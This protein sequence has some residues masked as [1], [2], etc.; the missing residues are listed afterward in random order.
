MHGVAVSWSDEASAGAAMLLEWLTDADF[1][2][3]V[4]VRYQQAVSGSALA[5]IAA[6]TAMP[7]TELAGYPAAAGAPTEAPA[8]AGSGRTR[9][10][11]LI[12]AIS[13]LTLGAL[14]FVG[15]VAAVLSL[16]LGAGRDVPAVEPQHATVA[17][18]AVPAGPPAAAPES[19][20]APASVF[21]EEHVEEVAEEIAGQDADEGLAELGSLWDA[22]PSR[23]RRRRR[24][25]R[26]RI[27]FGY[28]FSVRPAPE[29]VVADNDTTTSSA[30]CIAPIIIE[31]R[32]TPKSLCRTS[33]L[34]STCQQSS[35]C[36][37]CT[38]R[39]WG[40]FRPRISNSPVRR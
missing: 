3:V 17:R 35:V 31:Y 29:P 11:S 30:T 12:G 21:A 6:L 23:W 15:S 22:P 18:V 20:E 36:A 39:T 37:A 33:V 25:R 10:R 40:L 2:H 26:C 38:A 24:C 34:P 32:R 27:E 8:R 19:P 5:R 14:A 7:H 9:S 28:I 13:M 16:H 4:P 1:D